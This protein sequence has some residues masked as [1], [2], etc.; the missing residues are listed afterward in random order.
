M[1][2]AQKWDCI[3][4]REAIS[5]SCEAFVAPIHY[6]Q[7]GHQTIDWSFCLLVFVPF[8][9]GFHAFVKFDS[10]LDVTHTDTKLATMRNFVF[11]RQ[12]KSNKHK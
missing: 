7:L 9:F 6:C 11:Q 10:S 8:I 3:F 1:L 12:Y 2:N 4:L 5:N